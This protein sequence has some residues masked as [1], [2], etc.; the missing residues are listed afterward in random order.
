MQIEIL[1]NSIDKLK[2]N[3]KKFKQS[4]IRQDYGEREECETKGTNEPKQIIKTAD[5]NLSISIITSNVNS[6]CSN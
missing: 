3:N 6:S 2:W 4:R 1:K 5:L